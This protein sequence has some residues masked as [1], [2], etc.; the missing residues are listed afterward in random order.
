VELLRPVARA[1][2]G[3]AIA[4]RF[5]RRREDA[6]AALDE[7]LARF[8]GASDRELRAWVARALCGKGMALSA[9][10][11]AAEAAA[12]YADLLRRFGSAA[13]PE[14]REV[15]VDARRQILERAS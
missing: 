7:V 15:V 14:I 6:I 10:G 2:F 9:H 5:L 8:D 11:R 13:E 4:L 12:V 1:L 3:Q